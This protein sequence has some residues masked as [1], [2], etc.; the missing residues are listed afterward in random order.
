MNTSLSI[1]ILRTALSLVYKGILAVAI[2][3]FL[4]RH[5]HKSADGMYKF[6]YNSIYNF[7]A[8]QKEV[9]WLPIS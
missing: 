9:S 8:L 1:F 3:V 7:F 2:C 5:P 6:D 4:F